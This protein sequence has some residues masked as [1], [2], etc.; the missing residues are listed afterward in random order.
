MRAAIIDQ[1]C[2][3]ECGSQC[4]RPHQL[5]QQ[6]PGISQRWRSPASALMF[7]SFR[8]CLYP[9]PSPTPCL[10]GAPRW[11]TPGSFPLKATLYVGVSSRVT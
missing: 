1:K 4:S 8:L 7:S 10:L 9:P 2:G 11:Q 6:L 5:R 3:T